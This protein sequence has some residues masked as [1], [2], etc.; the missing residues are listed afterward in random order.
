M[1]SIS[2]LESLPDDYILAFS[3]AIG[4]GFQ[5]WSRRP[6]IVY[7]TI[8]A[9]FLKLGPKLQVIYARPGDLK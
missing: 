9:G 4:A 3:S 6:N 5:G 8:K 2:V 7:G 1:L